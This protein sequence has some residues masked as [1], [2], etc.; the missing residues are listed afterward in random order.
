MALVLCYVI[1]FTIIREKGYQATN[2]VKGTTSAKVK[3]SACIGDLKNYKDIKELLPLDIMDVRVPANEEGALFMLIFYTIFFIYILSNIAQLSTTA[4]TITKNQTRK[5]CNGNHR[6]PICTTDD[7]SACEQKLF[8]WDSQ[9]LFT[10]ECGDNGRCQM[11]RYIQFYVLIND[12][13][14]NSIAGVHSKIGQKLRL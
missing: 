3:G 5:F 10:G 8:S 6:V 11:V 14:K 9:G 12:K 1:G 13:C 4:R 7:T 2:T